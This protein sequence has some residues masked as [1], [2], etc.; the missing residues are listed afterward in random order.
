MPEFWTLVIMSRSMEFQSLGPV[1]SQGE[2]QN[3][4]SGK[5]WGLTKN[6]ASMTNSSESTGMM[7]LVCAGNL[8]MVSEKLPLEFWMESGE[9]FPFQL[10]KHL[11][12]MKARRQQ[13]RPNVDVMIQNLLSLHIFWNIFMDRTCRICHRNVLQNRKILSFGIISAKWIEGIQSVY[14]KVIQDERNYIETITREVTNQTMP[15][16]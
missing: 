9:K 7:F 2:V 12:W 14:R 16:N 3:Y 1:Y 10:L 6:C 15:Y 5:N 4:W 13:Q 8:L 11:C